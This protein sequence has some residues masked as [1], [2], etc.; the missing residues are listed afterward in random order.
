[1]CIYCFII[2]CYG[3]VQEVIVNCYVVEYQ[4]FVSF[5]GSQYSIEL[6]YKFYCK[7]E[8]VIVISVIYFWCCYFNCRCIFE[9]IGV[10]QYDVFFK[11]WIEVVVNWIFNCDFWFVRV[12]FFWCQYQ[13]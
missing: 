3:V 8:V 6:V 9:W 13:Y 5:D 2:I 12:G 11:D 10:V 4:W 7:G 1:M